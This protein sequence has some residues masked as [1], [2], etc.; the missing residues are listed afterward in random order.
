MPL[1]N[2]TQTILRSSPYWDDFSQDK[3]FHRILNKPRVPVQTR[4]LNQVQSILQNQIEQVTTGI[5]REGA[6]VTGGQ[7]T[8]LNTVIALQ[9]A[10]NEQLNINLLYNSETA[11]GATVRGT[12]SLAEA[13][14]VQVDSQLEVS[15]SYS[16]L[17]VTLIT[18]AMFEGGEEIQF[19]DSETSAQIGSAI[20]APEDIKSSPACVFCV[21]NGVFFLRGHLVTTPKQTVVMSTT[22]NIDSKRIGF[23]IDEEIIT[24]DDD[25]T[26]LD[27]ALETTNY[28]APGADRLRITPRLVAKPIRTAAG[29][30]NADEGFIEIA[31]VI[32]GIAQARASDRLEQSFIEDTLARRTYDESGDYVVNPFRLTVKDHRPSVGVPNITGRVNGNT[33]STIITAAES[34]PSRFVFANGFEQQVTTLFESEIFEGDIL[35]IR[36]EQREVTGIVSNTTLQVN[37]CFSQAF[38]AISP[39]VISSNKLNLELEAG[40]AYVRGYEFETFGTTKLEVARARTTKQINNGHIGTAFGPYVRVKHTKGLF[41]TQSLQR[42]D[43]HVSGPA[44]LINNVTSTQYNSTKIGTAFIR[45]FV[46]DS[47]VGNANTVYRAYLIG[48][49]F[50]NKE[51]SVNPAVANS[52]TQLTSVTVNSIAKTIELTQ[53]TSGGSTQC[54]LPLGDA[55]FVGATVMLRTVTGTKLSYP[56]TGS[57]YSNATANTHTQTLYVNGSDLLNTVNTSANI[58]MIFSDKCINGITDGIANTAGLRVDVSS[59]TNADLYNGTTFM[60]GATSTELLFPFVGGVINPASITDQNY[61]ITRKISATYSGADNIYVL[62]TVTHETYDI[63]LPYEDVIAINSG[64]TLVSMVGATYNATT[65]ELKIP[66]STGDLTLIVRKVRIPPANG[67]DN[68]RIKTLILAN[69]NTSNVQTL[70]S[71]L[72]T[73]VGTPLSRGHIAINE[74]NAASSSIVGLGVADVYAIQKIYAVPSATDTATWIDVTNNYTFD[75]GQRSWCYDHASIKLKPGKTHYTV[76]GCSQM[77]VMADVFVHSAIT[78]NANYFTPKS[79]SGFSLGD[80]P[81]FQNT[82]AGQS[83]FLSRVIDFRSVRTANAVLANTA[84]NPYV[85]SLTT[86]D[87]T[88]VPDPSGSYFADYD[89]YLPRIDKVVA[90]KEKQFRVIR[91]IPS[92]NPTP[93]GDADNGITLYVVSYPPYTANAADVTIIPIQHRRYTMRDIGKLEKRVENLEYYA[94]LSVLDR[95]TVNTPEYDENDVERFKNG[96]LTDSFANLSVGNFNNRDTKISLDKT[97]LEM[98]PTFIM[99]RVAFQVDID[100]STNIVGF[101]QATKMSLPFQ[102]VPLFTQGLASNSVNINPFAFVTWVGDVNLQPSQD[103]WIDTITRPD[104]TENQFNE[105]SGLVNGWNPIG[106]V[107]DHWSI[108]TVGQQVALPNNTA[109][110]IVDAAGHVLYYAQDIQLATP[111]Q[112]QNIMQEYQFGYNVTTVTRDLGE[113][114]VDT[115]V[116]PYLRGRNIDIAAKSLRPGMELL[117]TFDGQDVTAFVERAN[118]LYVANTTVASEFRVGDVIR[119]SSGAVSRVIGIT[120]NLLHVAGA[121]GTFAGTTISLIDSFNI[122]NVVT[123]SSRI[124]QV[125]NKLVSIY[126]P[127]HGQVS[128]IANTNGVW[129]VSIKP[130]GGTSGVDYP[131]NELGTKAYVGQPIFFTDGGVEKTYNVDTKQES[132]PTGGSTGVAGARATVTAYADGVLTLANVPTE[133]AAQFQRQSQVYTSSRPV[134]YSIGRPRTMG[135]LAGERAFLGNLN[136]SLSSTTAIRPGSFYGTFKLPGW[137]YVAG[138]Q[139][140]RYISSTKQFSTGERLFKLEN[141]ST[142]A[143][144]NSY[145][146]TQ[147]VG[148]GQLQTTQRVF[149]VFQEQSDIQIVPQPEQVSEPQ[150]VYVNGD[151]KTYVYI[152]GHRYELLGGGAL[153]YIDPL[154]QSFLIENQTYPYGVYVTHVDLFFARAGGSGIPITVKLRAMDAG[155][156]SPNVVLGKGTIDL[157]QIKV[158]PAGTTPDVSNPNHRTRCYFDSPVFLEA[159]LSYAISVETNSNEFE[160]FVA[161]M[162][163]KVIGTDNLIAE[164]PIGGVFFKSQNSETWTPEQTQDLMFVLYRADFSLAEGTLALKLANSVIETT[165]DFDYDLLQF[166][167]TYADYAPS[168]P[169]TKFLATVSNLN[170]TFV[171]PIAAQENATNIPLSERMSIRESV[172]GDLTLTATLRTNSPHVSPVYDIAG[173]DMILVKNLIDNGGLYAG[174][175]AVTQGVPNGTNANAKTYKL[176][177]SGGNGDGANVYFT[178]NS[179]GYVNGFSVIDGGFG[180]TQTPVVSFANTDFTSAPSFV[181]NGETSPRC[182]IAE[183]EKARYITRTVTLADGFD[184]GDLKVYLSASRSQS[185][186][187]EVYYKVLATGDPQQFNDKSWVLMKLKPEQQ[188]QYATAQAAFREYEYRTEDN[189]AT[190]DYNGTTFNRFHSFAIKIV[191]RSENKTIVPRVRNL[192]VLALDE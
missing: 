44:T 99:E 108:T 105:N 43:L 139:S 13:T 132:T 19:F 169:Y 41:D 59:K 103:T 34:Y 146:T 157:T 156:P 104:I 12:N 119:A 56:V 152:Q 93:P 185:D 31:R 84:T 32:D 55:S 61:Q 100:N 96:I 17:I 165:Q 80:I 137:K 176:Q 37:A 114:V 10:R 141:A 180:Y 192:R 67:S 182:D 154:A 133:F 101:D 63:G 183:E 94:A 122:Q 170:D 181:Y 109:Y 60:S 2:S 3:R 148:T 144:S 27:P 7:Q 20:V 89:V 124:G 113:R 115:S 145:A 6:A 1:S 187:I 92:E 171:I 22:T 21:D 160:L 24:A 47:G 8:I 14:I 35:V 131:T 78:A 158:I 125:Q 79:Y 151:V 83:V 121:N 102:T 40:K 162:G 5:F 106:S 117:A 95:Q 163:K 184:A 75:N 38:D 126:L 45:S 36:G 191:L 54:I 15:E 33:T 66:N 58:V 9:I 177:I 149:G 69:T 53:N 65:R 90:T 97:K 49:E 30:Q 143:S 25:T 52:N 134:R 135:L 153:K 116:I 178:T 142:S 51:Y 136:A 161:E 72:V 68:M 71:N 166:R 138:D 189:T 48:A 188:N 73:S 77:L 18:D 140:G 164:Q 112:T 23:E 98:R 107:W 110:H 70:T 186:N 111:V 46:Y 173:V 174:G 167:A 74:I 11:R 127:W 76:G 64:G 91:G 88:M 82:K 57:I 120:D 81:T 150:T 50:Q 86:F 29:T 179:T 85:A 190:Y 39:T 28:A 147:Y 129:T 118:H 172:D 62:P 155:V 4:E 87:E 128:S 130:S 123:D 175:F 16:A 168:R 26:L 42:V 159:G